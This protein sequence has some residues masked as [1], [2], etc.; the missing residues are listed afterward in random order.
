MINISRR[1][2]FAGLAMQAIIAKAPFTDSIPDE[3]YERVMRA[4]ALGAFDYADKMIDVSAKG[5]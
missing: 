3:E 1:D 2:Y 5:E 4:I